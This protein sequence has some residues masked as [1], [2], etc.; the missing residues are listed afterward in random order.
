MVGFA[1][2]AVGAVARAGIVVNARLRAVE[3]FGQLSKA[4]AASDN[5][6]LRFGRS[7]LIA[8]GQITL[9]TGALKILAN[10]ITGLLALVQVGLS[11]RSFLLY[12]RAA[13]RA[14]F[15]LELTGMSA[16]R[17]RLRLDEYRRTLGTMAARDLFNVTQAFSSVTKLTGGWDTRVLELGDTLDTM[18]IVDFP[19][20]TE[21]MSK[22]LLGSK[23]AF[24][25]LIDT[26]FPALKGE[27]TT[28]HELFVAL[29]DLADEENL[30]NLEQLAKSSAELQEIWGRPIGQI[31]DKL[32]AVPAAFA[33]A[34]LAA[35]NWGLDVEKAIKKMFKGFLGDPEGPTD[36]KGEPLPDPAW[37]DQIKEGYNELVDL[38]L[39]DWFQ[40]VD[41][42]LNA[43]E[44]GVL[45]PAFRSMVH[46]AGRVLG[47]LGNIIIDAFT[48]ST[49]TSSVSGPGG[50]DRPITTVTPGVV[51]RLKT[52]AAGAWATFWASDIIVAIRTANTVILGVFI[53]LGKLIGEAIYD[54]I[55]DS[56]RAAINLIIGMINSKIIDRLNM[57]TPVGPDIPRIPMIPG[58][59]DGVASFPGHFPT[60][61]SGAGSISLNL[62]IGDEKVDTVVLNSLDR[63]TRFQSG[64][65]PHSVRGA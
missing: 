17:S 4:I 11:T 29:V 21:N 1:A 16:S 33:D 55:V 24:D 42:V 45:T 49:S 62:Y 44:K 51:E 22:A 52:W 47:G 48:G 34:A 10:P 28:A 13:R 43:F 26:Y 60:Q 41:S 2:G 20:F 56:S 37:L 6:L 15:Q 50:G 31:M 7:A 58:G 57:V 12:E 59:G 64:L 18:G 38:F 5:R 35:T 27:V 63:I 8:S 36:W 61:V 14:Q 3:R 25:M 53:K 54:G 65:T 39:P 23:S 30:T 46:A 19:L 40:R 9:L 32:H